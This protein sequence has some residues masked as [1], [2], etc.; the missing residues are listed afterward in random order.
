MSNGR[1]ARDPRIDRALRHSVRDGMAS[2]AAQGGGETYFSAFALYLGASAPQVALLTTFP[3]LIGSLAQFLSAWLGRFFS[4]KQLILMGA[5]VHG[6]LWLPILIVPRELAEFAVFSLLLLYTVYH[7]AANLVAPQWTSLMR[8][9]VSERRR[10]R[11]F[12]HRTRFT[13]ISSFAALLVCG[14]ILHTFDDAGRT[15]IGF[16]V[17]FLIAFLG[18]AISVYHLTF[19]HDAPNQHFVPDLHVSH[20]FKSLRS[21]GALDFS[22]YF[23]SMNMAVGISSPFFAVYMLRDLGF[24]YLQFTATTGVS[25]FVQ[26]LTLNTWGRIADVYGNRAILI[27]TS[28]TLPAVPLL[29][30][31]SADFWYL[32]IAQCVSGLSWAGF[33]LSAG[34]LLY[35]LV[36]RTRRA[37][38]VA[39]HNVGTATA[40]FVGAMIGATLVA[41]VPALSPLLGTT[42][43]ASSLLVLFAISGIV[44]AVLAILLAR[45]VSELRKPRRRLSTPA[46]VLRIT[47]FTAMVG[48]LYEMIGRGKADTGDQAGRD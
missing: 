7:S 14:T 24:S 22:A 35:D 19:L 36:P 4:R 38:Y 41:I 15:Y 9:L 40:V 33:S 26:F 11:Y 32:T 8:D 30:L 25:V 13:T 48:L 17:I 2:S 27:V 12:G 21:T 34:N 20:W 43:V 39:F 47:G 37:V 23:I 16:V 10:G 18:R 5:S 29:W 6:C 45:R 1:F 31:V 3:A 44:R 46:L 28:I 42:Q